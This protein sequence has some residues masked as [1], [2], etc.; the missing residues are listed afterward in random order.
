[1]ALTLSVTQR[2]APNYTKTTGVS[3]GASLTYAPSLSNSLS[4]ATGTGSG[5]ADLLYAGT[6]TLAA[7]ATED[8]DL[9]G[10]FLQDVFGANLTFV[11]IKYIYV[12]AASGNTNN[13]IMG[14]ASATQFVGPFG[15]ATHT[16]AFV[17][18]AW[19]EFM[20]PTTGWTVTAGSTDLLKFANSAAGT[21]VSWDLV[22]AG[23]SV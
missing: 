11:K 19:S 1:M 9:A 20:H 3:G 10:T 16:L 17:P 22:I 18:G 14:G 15:A 2:L 12:K 6:R 4:L 23:T 8:I 7:S 13:V 21:S 5:Q